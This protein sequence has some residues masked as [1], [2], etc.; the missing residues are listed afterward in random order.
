MMLVGGSC[1]HSVFLVN[2]QCNPASHRLPVL[3]RESGNPGI[4][5]S[6]VVSL[7]KFFNFKFVVQLEYEYRPFDT[8]TVV[9]GALLFVFATLALVVTKVLVVPEPAI[10]GS[11]LVK[12]IQHKFFECASVRLE[13]NFFFTLTHLTVLHS[14]L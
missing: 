12:E 9:I 13:F 2:V 10:P 4:T 5:C 8:F 11:Y 6:K 14:M 7:G 3:I 1:T